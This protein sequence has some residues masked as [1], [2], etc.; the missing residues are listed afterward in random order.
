MATN[1]TR[2]QLTLHNSVLDPLRP[3]IPERK[4][5]TQ[6]VEDCLENHRATLDSSCIMGGAQGGP[7]SSFVVNKEE[8]ERAGALPVEIQQKPV[9]ASKPKKAKDPFTSKDIGVGLVPVDLREHADQIVDWWRVRKGT[10][11]ERAW[12]M[13]MDKLRDMTPQQRS[14]ALQRAYLKGYAT[15]FKPDANRPTQGYRAEPDLKH[16]AYR[17]SYDVLRENEELA[18][19]N[20]EELRRKKQEQQELDN[21]NGVLKDL[22]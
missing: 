21:P 17:D 3:Y 2:T 10:F 16:P 6:F 1:S 19:R 9:K 8:E 20:I 18:Q 5:L 22:F 11:S 12:N 7:P 13:S 4:S 14:E 15:V